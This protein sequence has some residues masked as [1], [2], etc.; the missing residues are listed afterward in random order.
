MSQGFLLK[1]PKFRLKKVRFFDAIQLL[2]VKAPKISK[3]DKFEV[4]LQVH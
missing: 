3:F 1:I 4:C 2:L